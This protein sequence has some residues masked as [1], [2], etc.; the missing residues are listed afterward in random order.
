[1]QPILWALSIGLAFSPLERTEEAGPKPIAVPFELLPTKHI[2]V[3]VRINGKGPYRCHL[4]HWCTC[5]A[6]GKPRGQRERR[7][8]RRERRRQ[9][10]AC[11]AAPDSFRSRS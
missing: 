11:L 4:R 9:S 3:Q 8:G 2:A 7:P 6:L 5:A 1:M 10:S